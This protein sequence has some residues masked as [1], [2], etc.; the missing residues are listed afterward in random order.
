MYDGLDALVNNAGVSYPETIPELT[1]D[2]LDDV[3]N[4]NL[5]APALLVARVGTAMAQAGRGG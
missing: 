1:A 4:V 5:R 3:L 2:R